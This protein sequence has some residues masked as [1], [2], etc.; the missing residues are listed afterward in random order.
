MANSIDPEN[1]GHILEF[2]FVIALVFA[3]LS[4]GLQMQT[5]NFSM[6]L[7]GN[8]SIKITV[9][10]KDS[11][12]P[13]SNS[14]VG[15]SNIDIFNVKSGSTKLAAAKSGTDG[16]AEIPVKTALL[17]LGLNS[18]PQ[19]IYLVAFPPSNAYEQSIEKVKYIANTE[20]KIYLKKKMP[21]AIKVEIYK[22]SKI[23][24]KDVKLL[25]ELGNKAVCKILVTASMKGKI[26]LTNK[27]KGCLENIWVGS[28]YKLTILPI[29]KEFKEIK[30]N[31]TIAK[32]PYAKKMTIK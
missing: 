3:F 18:M 16:K 31:I 7:A 4:L 1:K 6:W 24:A 19:N 10:E 26:E 14:T 8:D 23:Y 21:A 13:V 32:S 20:Y 29:N 30:E 5:G 27:T 25:L 9:L 17:L 2:A 15:V 12:K 11:L 28:G 22:G